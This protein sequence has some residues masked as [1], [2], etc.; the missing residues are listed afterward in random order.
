MS[1]ARSLLVLLALEFFKVNLSNPVK[2][3]L[4]AATIL[5]NAQGNIPPVA[6][7][8]LHPIAKPS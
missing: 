6:V 5:G 1:K 3:C 7:V 8:E 4:F 2:Q